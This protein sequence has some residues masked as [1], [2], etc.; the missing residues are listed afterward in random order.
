MVTLGEHIKTTH[1]HTHT[2]THEET[3]DQPEWST[4]QTQNKMKKLE[5]NTTKHNPTT[6]TKAQEK[7]Q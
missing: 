5:N 7:I 2:H 4:R 3:Q 1:T 6:G